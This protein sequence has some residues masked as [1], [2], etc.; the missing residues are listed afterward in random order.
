MQEP[1]DIARDGDLV[2]CTLNRPDRHNALSLDL[3][4]AL[5]ALL[6]D[7]EAD[8][9]G[10][11]IFTG[12]GERAFVSGADIR[13]LKARGAR[14]AWLGINARLLRRLELLDCPTL[15]A[16][17]GYA[18]GGGCEFALA[19]DLRIAAQGARF[20]QPEVGLGIVPGAGASYR[21]PRAVGH[22]FAAELILTGRVID[23]DEALARGLVSRVVAADAL[24][25]AART[26]A[27]AVLQNGKLAVQHA[28]RL[29]R[30]ARES[31]V[32]A[33]MQFEAAVQAELFE[34]PDKHARMQRFL[35]RKR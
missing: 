27:A 2:I 26:L 10:A 4:E 16:V 25:P 5:H 3:V 18:L 1:L 14:E 8:P 21:L 6:A 22:A 23:A 32:E 30:V 31:S 34:H 28:K 33:A 20:G 35:E 9:P 12:A 24:M 29:L 11:A 7:L 19:C 13:E 17:N 15:A